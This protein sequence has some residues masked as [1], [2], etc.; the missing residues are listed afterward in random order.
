MVTNERTLCAHLVLRTPG[1]AEVSVQVRSAHHF[2]PSGPGLVGDVEARRR[3][4]EQASCRFGVAGVLGNKVE[5]FTERGPSELLG[6][7]RRVAE[8][9]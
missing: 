1:C 3:M 9:Q 7:V 4:P 8:A 6:D 2:D 5:R